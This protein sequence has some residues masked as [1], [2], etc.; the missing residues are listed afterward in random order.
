MT[1]ADLLEVVYSFYP[2]GLIDGGLGFEDTEEVQ[3][4][5]DAARRGGAE[6]PRWKAMIGRL[7]ARYSLWDRSLHL[8]AGGR[9]PAYS[10]TITIPGRMLGFHVSLLGPY[11]GIHRTDAAGEEAVGLD[12]AR[13]IEATY[14]GHQPIPLELGDEVVP[15]VCP[16]GRA[17]VYRCLLS[18]VWEESSGPW[19]P[20]PVSP[21]KRAEKQAELEAASARLLERERRGL[22]VARPVNVDADAPRPPAKPPTGST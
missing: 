3:R 10:A 15:E 8:L 4:Q 12:L 6:Y 22:P 19:P 18:E 1:R 9:D 17:T 13:E 14:P 11:Y 7:G 21:E 5:R 20:P 2:R 16:F